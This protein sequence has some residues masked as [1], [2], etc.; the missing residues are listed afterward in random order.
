MQKPDTYNNILNETKDTKV[1]VCKY[2]ILSRTS[3][4]PLRHACLFLSKQLWNGVKIKKK[5]I[6]P[7]R[8]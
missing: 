8:G 3:H 2:E 7:S 1:K 5:F 6:V 4:A